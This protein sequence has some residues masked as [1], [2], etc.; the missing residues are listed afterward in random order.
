MYNVLNTYE[1]RD[2][3]VK[4]FFN[5]L[6]KKIIFPS[7][8]VVICCCILSIICVLASVAVLFIDYPSDT[9]LAFINA[10]FIITAILLVY[11]VYA[12]IRSLD[13]LIAFFYDFLE[14]HDFLNRLVNDFGYRTIVFAINSFAFSIA[15]GIYNGAVGIFSFSMWYG[16]LAAYYIL[17]AF[18]RGGTLLHHRRRR[19]KR[20]RY[21]KEDDLIKYRNCGILLVVVD[22][23][24]A[25]E[26]AQMVL[27]DRYFEY[28][29]WTIYVSA[30]YAVIKVTAA[31]F[32]FIKSI[33]VKVLTVRAIRN[34]NVADALVSILALQTSLLH[35]F[36]DG[37]ITV[38]MWLNALTGSAV[39]LAT[40][41]L[42]ICMIC[43][44]SSKMKKL[45]NEIKISE[46]SANVAQSLES[47]AESL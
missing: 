34:I 43:F 5:G 23:A 11:S 9:V 37:N 42:G 32:N 46:T 24:L 13:E 1:R 26:I 39:A 21:G 3:K 45:K 7:V 41:S 18:M 38:I 30:I 19:S 2:V 31:I 14:K 44:S 35:T 4:K 28:P 6:I 47:G 25:V 8:P 22:V 33:N 40:L 10:L 16:A 36:G 20:G 17:L 15:Y 12:A 27:S 29:D